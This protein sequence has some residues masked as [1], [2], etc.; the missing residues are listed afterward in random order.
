MQPDEIDWKIIN[1]LRESHQNNN[2]IA[3]LLGISEGDSPTTIK[4]FERCRDRQDPGTDK[5]GSPGESA[6]GHS[7]CKCLGVFSSSSQRQKR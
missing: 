5:P 3:R 1:T 4:T 7:C 2:A 6:V